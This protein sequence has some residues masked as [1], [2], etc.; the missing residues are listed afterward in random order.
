MKKVIASACLALFAFAFN[1]QADKKA[2]EISAEE[3]VTYNV[4][5]TGVTWAGCKRDVSSAFNK[6]AGVKSVSIE[7]GEK[8]G[9]QNVVVTSTS[10]DLTKEQAIASLGA[11]AKRYVVHT[12]EKAE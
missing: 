2:P 11:K 6:L 7:K 1:V 8:A 3:V 10:G 5:M 12:F 9:T 4:G